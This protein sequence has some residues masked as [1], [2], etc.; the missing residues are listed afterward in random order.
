MEKEK[1][2][3]VW[4]VRSAASIFGRA[5]SW[6]KEAGRPLEFASQETAEAYAK[7]CNSRTTAN[8]HYFVK[9]KE[10]EP[11]AV[12]KD[13]TQPD[14]A[15]R[16]HEEQTPRN[17]AVEK[18][19]EIP[20]R[21]LSK[22]PDP[23]VEIRSAVHSNYA[24]MVAMLAA[25]NRVYLGREEHYHYQ[26]GLTSY[27]DN[28][29]GSLCF[30]T[31]RA[32]MYYF[33][34][35]EGWAHCPTG[36]KNGCASS[37]ML[38]EDDLIECVQ[39]SLKGHIENVASL[40]SLLSSISQERINLEL[41][42]EYAGQIRANE[43]QL[44]QIEGFKTKLYENLVSGILTKEEYLSY[45]RKYN[46]DIELLQKAVAEWEERLTDVLENRSER[47][48]WINHFMQFSTMEEIDRRAVM[49]LIRSIRVISKDEL[50]IEFNYQ[51]EY[52]KAVALA[53]QIVEQAAER[54]VG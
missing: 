36:K 28:G 6:C 51:D 19:N 42:Q 54:K 38:K 15:A 3:G 25:D 32:D 8:V 4:A 14:R 26:D 21:Q 11:G 5:E 2:Y 45:K 34:Y 46:A 49:Q 27:Y 10:P 47:N 1:T 40:D 20:G 22:D 12:R 13:G 24:G 41:A 23:L 31:D 18:L 43:K 29:D 16:A 53:E 7:E 33:L 52:K 39:D 44:A 9:E 35:G 37:V 50:H 30:V 48:R 17:A